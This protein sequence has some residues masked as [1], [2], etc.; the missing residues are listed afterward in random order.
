MAIKS[1][2]PTSPPRRYYQT[3]DFTGLS[4]EPGD[5][6]L[7]K[8]ARKSGGRNNQGRI[9]SRRRGGGHKRR[10]RII[11]FRRDKDGVPATVAAIEYDPNRSAHIALLNYADG[12]KRYILS[13]A[14]LKA[15]DKV[16]SGPTAEIRPGNCLMLR[17]MPLGTFVHNV[18][19][20]PGKG[21]QL[22]RS[23]GNSGQVLAREGEYVQ[24]RMPTGEVRM[25]RGDCRATV[26]QVSNPDHINVK[27][28]KAGRARY[29]GKRPKVRG[30]SMNPIDHPMGG[31]EGRTSGGRHP[32]SPWGWPTKGHKTRKARKPSNRY[33]VRRRK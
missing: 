23:A 28:G 10:Y 31:G 11:D 24:I 16:M 32:C 30:V 7:L 2:K 3:A 8:K 18:E 27:W 13:P 12:E 15:G 26:G 5:G 19:L 6:K 14:G 22:I 4:K 9:T 25:F 29:L 17:R 33:I 1:Y 21:G 20:Q